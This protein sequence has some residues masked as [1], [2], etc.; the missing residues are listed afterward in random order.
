VAM[1]LT[2]MV[3]GGDSGTATATVPAPDGSTPLL[4]HSFYF[5]APDSAGLML[6]HWLTEVLPS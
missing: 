3:P 5:L 2:A 6:S 4:P 1:T